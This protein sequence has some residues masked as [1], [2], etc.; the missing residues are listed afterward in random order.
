VAGA[1]TL[2]ARLLMLAWV[3]ALGI[4]PVTNNDF[5]YHLRIGEDILAA[6]A[7]PREDVYAAVPHGHPFIAQGWLAAVIMALVGSYVAPWGFT[8]LG[9]LAGVVTAVLLYLAVPRTLRRAPWTLLLLAFAFYLT[10][11]AIAVRPVVFAT[12]ILAGFVCCLERWRRSR[13][14]RNLVPLVAL[15]LLWANLHGSFLFGP[16]LLWGVTD[17]RRR[18]ARDE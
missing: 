7:I 17:Q 6:G 10:A 18:P 3:V 12:P 13:R 5:W 8:L 1:I 2:G 16:V 15:E 11:F 9:D 14:V 4:R